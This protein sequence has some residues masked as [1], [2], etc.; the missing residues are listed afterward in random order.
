VDT[1]ISVPA[2][3]PQEKIDA[4]KALLRSQAYSILGTI[5]F[6]KENFPGAQDNLQKSIDVYPSDPDP[7]VILRWRWRSISRGKYP[8]ALKAANRVVGMTQETPRLEPRRA[9]NA[10]ACNNSLERGPG[11]SSGSGP[12]ADSAE[13]LAAVA[14]RPG[15][16]WSPQRHGLRRGQGRRGNPRLYQISV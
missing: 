8:D 5:E 9:A 10:T 1:D 14:R 13:E 12:A 16:A 6:K 7:V 3:A 15:F 4:Y 2:G 11:S